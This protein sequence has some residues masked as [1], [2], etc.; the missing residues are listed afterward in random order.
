MA[1]D[2]SPAGEIE[3]VIRRFAH[4]GSDGHIMGLP[5]A[6]KVL[7]ALRSRAFEDWAR[8][9]LSNAL[10]AYDA[11][12]REGS[13][14]RAVYAEILMREGNAPDIDEIMN[15]VGA[16]QACM[17]CSITEKVALAKLIGAVRAAI[18]PEG[19]RNA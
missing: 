17:R 7:A 12:V 18:Q 5:E 3:A 2:K 16:E 11:A 14:A 19:E 13:T 6:E 15:R 10:A 8:K 4:V 9:S 1:P